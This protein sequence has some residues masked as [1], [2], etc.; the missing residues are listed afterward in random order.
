[1]ANATSTQLQELYVAYFGRAADPNGLDYWTEKGIT[2]SKF[3]ADMY[4]QAEFKDV[5]GSLSTE[6]QVNQIYKNLF[7][8]EAD[9]T[10][11]NYWTL[12]VNL[13]NLQLA[14]IATH[15]IWAAQNNSGSSDDKT[16]LTNRTDAAVAYTAKVKESAASILAFTAETTSP[17]KA[18]DNITE[19]ISYLSG[20]DKDTAHTAA[21]IAASVTTITNNGAPGNK[22]SFSLTAGINDFT[23]GA[24]ADTFNANLDTNS[25]NTLNAF[26][27]LVGGGGQD[28]LYADIK[29]A[30][31]PKT[32]TGIEVF[33]ATFSGAVTFGLANAT[34]ATSVSNVSSTS[35]ATFTGIAATAT[36]LAVENVASST[37]NFTY[38]ATSGTQAAT[39]TVNNLTGGT[40]AEIEIDGIETLT[41]NA[42]TA[43]SSYEIDADAATT[44]N[45]GGAA[46]QTVILN[47]STLKVSK[48]DAS[49]ATGSVTLTTINQTG[50][51]GGTDLSIIGGA[52]NDTFTSSSSTSQNVSLS[53]G[54]GN[55][56]F[57]HTGLG[58][59]DTADGGDGTDTMSMLN[60]DAIALDDS[61]QTNFTNI[62]AITITDEFDGSLTLANIASSL[63]TVNL[64]LAGTA[65]IDEAETITGPAGSLTVNLGNKDTSN[66]GGTLGATL[67]FT[68]T[69][70]ATTDTLYLNN[71]AKTTAGANIDMISS[72]DITSTG[73]ENI[74]F[75][76]GTGSGAADID[77]AT[78]TIT[79]DAITGTPINLTIKG[80]NSV[81]FDTSITTTS[82]GL[83]TIDAS[84]LTAQGS[85]VNTFQIDSTSQGTSGTANITGSPGKDLITVGAFA[86][87]ISGG[88]GNDSLTGGT[89]SKDSISG[90]DGNDTITGGGGNDTLLGGAGNDTFTVSGTNV[91]VDGGAGDDTIDMDSTLSSGD[92]VAGGAGTADTLRVNAAAT[93]TAAEGVSGFEYFETGAGLTQDMVLMTGNTGFTRIT[94]NY[95]ASHAFNNVY[96]TTTELRIITVASTGST[97]HSFDRLLDNSSNALTVGA[98]TDANTSITALTVNDEETLTIDD[99]AITTAKAL[100]I[101]TLTAEDM[102]TLNIT[103]KAN[104]DVAAFT[105]QATASLT[106][107]D[108][109][110]N[111]GTI[112]LTFT[113]ATNGLTVTGASTTA[114]TIVGGSGA[115]SITGGTAI[116]VLTGGA[117][118]DTL[119]GGDGADI[120]TGG[121]GADSLVGG[122]GGDTLAD[123][124][125]ADTVTGGAGVD[126]FTALVAGGVTTVT[127]FDPSGV[128]V[129]SLSNADIEAISGVTAFI[130][131]NNSDHTATS[132]LTVVSETLG[133]A[134]DLAGSD[135]SASVIA[136]TDNF[137]SAAE[138]QAAFRTNLSVEGTIAAGDAFLVLWDDGTDTTLAVLCATAASIG[139]VLGSA[140]VTEMMKFE[141]VGDATK[142][143]TADFIATVA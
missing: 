54:A 82:T 46:D 129:I 4:V 126:T 68:D 117:G 57:T 15:L 9:V 83:L 108:A 102:V 16:A 30:V 118:A 60:A 65:I 123:G 101:S 143:G 32:L 24:S 25:A 49:A 116:D 114:N 61:T 84:G 138:A 37:T 14:E 111:T 36:T 94:A 26:D 64:T 80:T 27:E 124:A 92:T 3:A 109:S 21:G 53:G 88:G 95:N 42:S 35:N 71:V 106:T 72:T 89:A 128:D 132:A 1:M 110:G 17:W 139:V 75:S 12:Q 33:N 59:S 47:T 31:T 2:T 6:A 79:P 74:V 78:L 44:L 81:H 58:T 55:D 98:A 131:L 29:T 104:V 22:K 112:D 38:L 121:A 67:T 120:L 134:L 119:V 113:N 13:G 39:V 40:A 130:E 45:F 34:D 10:G 51:G 11:L 91:K 66:A 135:T 105:A 99:G 107:V 56:L 97:A 93:A 77:F 43:E 28:T 141:G 73:Y 48:F 19:A 100:I 125:G 96:N 136:F 69:D 87:T 137:S 142:F 18:G 86:S 62:E 7:D 23:G 103:G 90:G 70:S 122:A 8:R 5:Y 41:F 20:I 133:T 140:T 52:G 63:D 85:N 76:S 127:D 50:V 115:D